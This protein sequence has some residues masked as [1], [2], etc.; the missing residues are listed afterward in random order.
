LI[1]L[2]RPLISWQ[3]ISI[4][5]LT[6][7]AAFCLLASGV[8]LFEFLF[9]RRSNHP[10]ATKKKKGPEAIKENEKV[11]DK[12]R[13]LKAK[14]TQE[15]NLAYDPSRRQFLKRAG[16]VGLLTATGFSGYGV[17][18][19][20]LKP[21]IAQRTVIYSELP[22]ALNGL[23]IGQVTDVHIGLWTS[24][25]DLF[26]ALET[27]RA[28][29]PDLVVFTGDLVDRHFENAALFIEPLKVLSETPLGVY[30]ILGNH[31]YYSGAAGVANIL[32]GH[33]LTLLRD[34]RTLLEKAPITL[35]GLNDSLSGMKLRRRA[36]ISSNS[37]DQDPD[38]LNFSKVQGPNRREGDFNILLNHRPE[39]YRQA[40]QMGFDL[41]LAG[42]T[43]GGQYRVPWAPEVNVASL[44]YKYTHGLYKE[45]S[46]WLNV[47]QGLGSVGIPF[48]LF[49]W[50]EIDLITVRKA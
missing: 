47:S 44:F 49:A 45:H 20:S 41:F 17:V 34:Q 26:R 33:G 18:R 5:I 9:I 22:S 7:A 40:S 10:V 4:L 16:A 3:I 32:N 6:A 23:T 39:G 15:L 13:G 14:F 27:L 43:H 21:S 31:D 2:T 24:Q 50:P 37:I 36:F 12:G 35:V 11:Q 28:Q 48:R 46:A 1:P 25:D 29:K 42:H 8:R 19:Q 38:V 30:G